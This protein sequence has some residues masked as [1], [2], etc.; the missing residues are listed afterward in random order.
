M[1]DETI[2]KIQ[3]RKGFMTQLFKAEMFN[4]IA[5]VICDKTYESVIT[6]MFKL[7]KDGW[8]FEVEGVK[9]SIALVP[10]NLLDVNHMALSPETHVTCEDLYKEERQQMEIEEET[11]EIE[12]KSQD[13]ADEKI[14]EDFGKDE[15]EQREVKKMKENEDE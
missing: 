9:Y 4:L 7:D 14:M 2:A 10:F 3:A 6:D 1:D 5:N 13:E 8:T 12:K 11:K 15:E